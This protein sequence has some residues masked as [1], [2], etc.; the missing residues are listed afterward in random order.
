MRVLQLGKF[1][2]LIGGVEKV[3]YD[4]TLGLSERGIH[5]DMM[6]TGSDGRAETIKLNEYAKLICCKTLFK[7]AAT[8][9][10][11][12]M[13]RQLKNVCSNYDIIH[14][15][16]PDPMACLALYLSGYKGKVMLHWH[17][18]ILK[19]RLLL[20]FY[21]PLQRWLLN[22]ADLIVGTSPLYIKESPYLQDV[23][24]KTTY[25]PIGIN[26]VKY[27]D[28]EANE[29]RKKYHNKKIIFGMGRLVEYKGFS[30]LIDAA[31]Y[32]SNEYLIIIGGDGPLRSVLEEQI[33]NE[34]LSDKVKLIGYVPEEKLPAYY[35]ACE[36]FCLSSIYRTE[37]FAIVQ[38]EAMSCGK[39][40]VATTIKGSGVSWV[41]KNGFSGLNVEPGN[42]RKLAEAIISICS[43]SATYNIFCEQARTRF[44]T[45]F[46]KS[47]M[48]DKCL[49]LYENIISGKNGIVI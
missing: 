44:E 12:D 25:A 38:V 27:S 49:T 45:C 9:V 2:P 8:T 20:K 7:F 36:L 13:I 19:Q 28:D 6:C 48:I 43:D 1:Y 3:M 40:V 26:P 15:H 5:C 42:S 16:H 31:R 47:L 37:A 17:S 11:Y 30:Y 23:Q 10:S 39:P 14:I 35:G 32:L 18:D 29:L 46:E 34:N 4:L 22:R 41:N 21:I 33:R 24:Y